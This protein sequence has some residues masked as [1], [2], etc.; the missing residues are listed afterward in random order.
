[1]KPL[2]RTVFAMVSL[3]TFASA[4]GEGAAPARTGADAQG[5]SEPTVPDVVALSFEAKKPGTRPLPFPFVDGKIGGRPTRL[6][7]DTGALVHTIDSALATA[8]GITGTPKGSVIS[9]DGWGKLPDRAVAVRELTPTL[10][11]HG[12]GGIIS[13]Q[14]LI[15]GGQ[16]VVVDLVNHELRMRVRAAAW[17][18]L[19]SIGP[20]LTAPGTMPCAADEGGLHGVALV[21]DAMI[22]G[23]P[24][25]LAFDTGSSRTILAQGSKAGAKV[26][27]HPVVGRSVATVARGDIPTS[28]YG[29][30]PVT[31]G[32]LST[33]GEVGLA[34]QAGHA[35][36]GH[37]GRVG[38]DVLKQCVL[39][40]T[41]D[42]LHVACRVPS[43]TGQSTH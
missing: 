40:M 17:S 21:A 14:L 31:I 36:C 34:P 37:E 23:E 7:I 19:G 12:I 38:V 29:G 25:Q 32:G 10:R 4:C 27:A 41:K 3:L 1:M 39:A 5:A 18:E 26:E 43:G 2:A 15:V 8:A 13:P 11:A 22:E 20:V 42:Q 35:P 16:A 24:V 28:L 9:I 33:T 6:L 30:V